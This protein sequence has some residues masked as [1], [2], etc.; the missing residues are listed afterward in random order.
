VYKNQR[1]VT[2]DS[3]VTTSQLAPAPKPSAK[4]KADRQAKPGNRSVTIQADQLNYFDEGHKALYSGHVVLNT[5]D[6][7]LQ[8][9]R[10]EVYFSEKRERGNSQIKR[11]L[12]EGHVV[13]TQPRRYATGDRAAFDADTGKIVMTGGPPAIYDADKGYS[14]GQRLTFYI[15]DDRLL[16]DGGPNSPTVTKHRVAQ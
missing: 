9:D 5:Q 16:I 2:T 13:V 7:K 4:D 8:A 10:L 11:A 6:T 1:R 3:R 12:A 14:S 15:H